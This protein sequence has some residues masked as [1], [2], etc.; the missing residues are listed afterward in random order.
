M[1]V[2]ADHITATLTL[3]RN[4]GGNHLK[5]KA[6]HGLPIYRIYVNLWDLRIDILDLHG[7]QR[8]Y[9]DLQKL[10]MEGL[11]SVTSMSSL[12]G[13]AALACFFP[14]P[15]S[16]LYVRGPEPFLDN[17]AFVQ[18]LS[19]CLYKFCFFSINHRQVS[20]HSSLKALT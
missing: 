3:H 5:K 1:E 16:S 15:G 17:V 4:Q 13:I 18:A 6:S 10:A 2:S 8:I 11:H 12:H 9:E 14:G 7:F 20:L 19:R